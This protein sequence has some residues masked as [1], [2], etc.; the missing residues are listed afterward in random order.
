MGGG[1][2]VGGG[3]PLSGGYGGGAGGAAGAADIG[4]PGNSGMPPEIEEQVIRAMRATGESRDGFDRGAPGRDGA[5][6]EVEAFL[7]EHFS[8]LKDPAA[9]GMAAPLR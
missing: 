8:F 4:L 5:N 9:I 6:P 3:V 7:D 1:D 2:A